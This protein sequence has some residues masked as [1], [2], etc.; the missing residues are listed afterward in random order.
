MY[1]VLKVMEASER[2]SLQGLDIIAADC[3]ASFVPLENTNDD[4]EQTGVGKPVLNDLRKR[5]RKVKDYLKTEYKVHCMSEENEC[6]DHCRK[7]GL[8]DSRDK[9]FQCS[10]SHNQHNIQCDNCED[11]KELFNNLEVV[12]NEMSTR[13]YSPEQKD[14]FLHDLEEAKEQIF[15]WKA[16][17]LHSINQEAAKS[18]IIESLD[19]HSAVIVMDLAMEFLQTRYREKQPD[20]FGKR[21]LSWHISSVICKRND[22][23][24]Q[25]FSY[26]HLFD[27]CSQDWYAVTSILE[28]LL[29]NNGDGEHFGQINDAREV[30]IGTHLDDE[31]E[32]DPD[33]L[34][35][36]CL[37]T[38]CTLIQIV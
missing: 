3:A 27:P 14:D 2:R 7:F 20:W 1:R 16:H 10:C 22:E 19:K 33:Q 25:I 30:K 34:L 4:L 26:A 6:S 18:K 5:I 29:Q 35:F 15:E 21:G 37:E 13:F 17:T 11:L 9:D 31:E 24:I 32:A 8:S 12:I 38:V 28:N 23:N 36:Y